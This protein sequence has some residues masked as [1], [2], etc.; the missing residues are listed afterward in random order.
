MVLSAET[1]VLKY[2]E[3]ILKFKIII[4]TENCMMINRITTSVIVLLKLN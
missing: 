2:H 4:L 3:K 1:A